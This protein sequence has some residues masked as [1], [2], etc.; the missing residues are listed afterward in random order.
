MKVGVLV[1]L[2]TGHLCAC[3]YVR[4]LLRI[5]AGTKHCVSARLNITVKQEVH[6]PYG[7][8]GDGRMCGNWTITQMSHYISVLRPMH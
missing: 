1:L 8:A 7:Q 2:N 3:T 5:N 4:I 6:G